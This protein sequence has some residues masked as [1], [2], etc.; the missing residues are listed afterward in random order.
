MVGARRG[1]EIVADHNCLA[2]HQGHNQVAADLI[3]GCDAFAPYVQGNAV[4]R[5]GLKKVTC[6]ITA[7]HTALDSAR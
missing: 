7:N 1:R 2:V 3:K 5:G 6:G 4:T